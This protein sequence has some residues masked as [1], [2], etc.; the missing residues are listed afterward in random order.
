[1]HKLFDAIYFCICPR[2]STVQL[3]LLYHFA[4]AFFLKLDLERK[5]RGVERKF[6]HK[7]ES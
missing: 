4:S 1:M 5:R 6:I 2:N 3:K 7:L